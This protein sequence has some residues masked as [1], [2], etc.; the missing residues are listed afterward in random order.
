MFDVSQN[1]AV[2]KAA[3]T[4]T[5]NAY[6]FQNRFAFLEKETKYS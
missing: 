1:M 5:G 2:V 4:N 3:V 6:Y